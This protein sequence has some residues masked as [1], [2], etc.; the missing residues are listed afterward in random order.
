L[1]SIAKI[2]CSMHHGSLSTDD[3]TVS[4]AICT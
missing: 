1:N 2:P 3:I 4:K